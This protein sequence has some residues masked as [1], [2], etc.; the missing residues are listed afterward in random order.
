MPE[1][2]SYFQGESIKKE[3]YFNSQPQGKDLMMGLLLEYI[4]QENQ[5]YDDH[6]DNE[7]EEEEY[8]DDK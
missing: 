5:D 2:I 7:Y 8:E 4:N 6:E 3:I 1:I